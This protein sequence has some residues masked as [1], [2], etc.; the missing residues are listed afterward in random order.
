LLILEK[1]RISIEHWNA[2]KEQQ[3]LTQGQWRLTLELWLP[4][5][6]WKVNVEAKY[7]AV[8]A[9]N[10]AG[11]GSSLSYGGSLCSYTV[12]ASTVVK[13]PPEVYP[14][15]TCPPTA[16]KKR[17]IHYTYIHDDCNI[18]YSNSQRFS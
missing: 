12:L 6:L 9:P 11:V 16:T 10:V 15:Y 4:Q 3:K 17:K 14:E 2:T 5:K 8:E 18:T 13:Y 7:G 1:E